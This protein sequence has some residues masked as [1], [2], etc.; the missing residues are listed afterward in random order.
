MLKNFQVYFIKEDSL[1]LKIMEIIDF[2]LIELYVMYLAA[3][4]LQLEKF[5]KNGQAGPQEKVRLCILFKL[6]FAREA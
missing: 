2:F 4:M 1:N 3:Q 5:H 6:R